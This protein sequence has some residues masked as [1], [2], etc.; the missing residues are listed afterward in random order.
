MHTTHGGDMMKLNHI[1]IERTNDNEC[2]THL[3]FNDGL[4][5]SNYIFIDLE[6]TA[7]RI[8]RDVIDDNPNHEEICSEEVYAWV[9][10]LT[11]E[12]R[13]RIAEKVWEYIDNN[14]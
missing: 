12:V 1:T 10:M 7:Q 9:E 5:T 8:G 6:Q 2:P 13:E 3:Y 11:D 14:I 4:E